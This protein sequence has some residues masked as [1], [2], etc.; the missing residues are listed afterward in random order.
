MISILSYKFQI[1]KVNRLIKE[2][3]NTCILGFEEDR[4]LINN[5][6]F[7]SLGSKYNLEEI[8]KNIFASLRKIDRLKCDLAIIEG[9]EE[10]NLGISIMNRLLRACNYNII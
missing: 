7:I 1:E 9:V 6:K 3:K 10:K 8:S 2:N 5:D 4:K